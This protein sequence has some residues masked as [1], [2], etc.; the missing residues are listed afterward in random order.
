MPFRRVTHA[1]T[2]LLLSA[3]VRHNALV[4]WRC[5]VEIVERATLEQTNMTGLV[6]VYN[7]L[8]PKTPAGPK[9]FSTRAKAIERI[10]AR[11]TELA[12]VDVVQKTDDAHVADDI[13]DAKDDRIKHLQGG[14]FDGNTPMALALEDVPKAPVVESL[15]KPAPLNRPR[16]TTIKQMAMDLLMAEVSRS[17]DDKAIGWTYEEILAKIKAAFPRC[18]TSIACLR[19][20]AVHMRQD[21][22]R[23]PLRPRKEA[24]EAAQSDEH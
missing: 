1:E 21:E 2:A 13:P 22:F 11:Q 16:V 3:V 15:V 17:D 8:M 7:S 23:L 6:D 14:H 10:I 24:V 9:T 20:Y 5:N 18:K 4:K 12:G 19:W